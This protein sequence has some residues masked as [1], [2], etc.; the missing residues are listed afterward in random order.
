[1]ANPNNNIK[2]EVRCGLQ[3]IK[4]VEY[5]DITTSFAEKHISDQVR[6]LENELRNKL[7]ETNPQANVQPAKIRLLTNELGANFYPYFITMSDN[8]LVRRDHGNTPSIFQAATDDEGVAIKKLYWE[9]LKNFRYDK[10]DRAN[11]R[12]SRWRRN[13]KIHNLKSFNVLMNFANPRI[14]KF[15]TRNGSVN[16][17][18]MMIDPLK[19][20]KHMLERPDNHVMGVEEVLSVYPEAKTQLQGANYSFR[21]RRETSDKGLSEDQLQ[22]QI[23]EMIMRD[24]K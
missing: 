8:V 18:V 7:R 21:I 23:K 4:D 15:E 14:E 20:W 19:L 3:P 12:D 24:M 13:V 11:F 2:S 1:M 10:Y 6:R 17:V 22:E 9:Y 16:N 5:Y